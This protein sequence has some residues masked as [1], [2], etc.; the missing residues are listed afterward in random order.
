MN[1]QKFYKHTNEFPYLNDIILLLRLQTTYN[2]STGF[3]ASKD[4]LIKKHIKRFAL[5]IRTH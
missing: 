1:Q 3:M 4:P 5:E 2:Q